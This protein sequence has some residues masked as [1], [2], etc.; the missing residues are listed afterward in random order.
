ML[1]DGCFTVSLLSTSTLTDMSLPYGKETSVT[2][3]VETQIQWDLGRPPD[4]RDLYLR[5]RNG[6]KLV[7]NFYQTKPN[8]TKLLVLSS[9]GKVP[10]IEVVSGEEKC[11]YNKTKEIGPSAELVFTLQIESFIV[12]FFFMSYTLWFLWESRRRWKKH[13]KEP[14]EG[15]LLRRYIFIIRSKPNHHEIYSRRIGVLVFEQTRHRQPS[16]PHLT[17]NRY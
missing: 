2:C 4:P 14:K 5:S 9:D 13:W 16:V 6:N 15:L 10:V 17:S 11:W 7:K 1:K 12:D 8:K 3:L